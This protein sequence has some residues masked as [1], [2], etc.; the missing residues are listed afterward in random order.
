MMIMI[1]IESC[2]RTDV[3]LRRTNNEDAFVTATEPALLALGEKADRLVRDACDAG[4]QDNVT[5]VLG[6]VLR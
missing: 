4:G 3:G 2:G 5:V 6:V 1:R